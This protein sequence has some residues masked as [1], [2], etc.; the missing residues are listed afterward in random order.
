MIVDD[1]STDNSREIAYEFCNKDD[2]FILMTNQHAKGVSGARNTGIDYAVQS[3]DWLTFLDADDELM[4]KVFYVYE[5]MTF[6]AEE[7]IIQ[8]NHYRNYGRANVIKYKNTEGVYGL[9]NMPQ[10]WCMVWNK[11]IRCDFIGDTRF[12]DGM[13]YGED[14]VFILDL[15]CKDA[16]IYHTEDFTVLRHFDNQNSL[17]HIKKR[18]ELIDQARALESFLMRSD[19]ADVNYFVC[20]TLSEHWGSKH[21]KREFCK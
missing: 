19:N 20:D 4:P 21:Y 10:Q 1:H 12:V 8:T 15:L 6:E 9:N 17:S 18:K 5:R 11:L 3:S 14:E 16:R 2:R 7:N 13:Q